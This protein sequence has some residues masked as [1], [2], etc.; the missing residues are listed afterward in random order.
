MKHFSRQDFSTYQ[1]LF[2]DEDDKSVLSWMHKNKSKLPPVR[3]DCGRTDP[4]IEYNRELHQ[5]L[6]DQGIHHTYDEFPGGHEW[7]YWAA[8]I[9]ET[10]LF[11]DACL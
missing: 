6:K 1:V 4:L 10:L 7:A 8:H 5:G 2:D 11:F 3:F 9:R